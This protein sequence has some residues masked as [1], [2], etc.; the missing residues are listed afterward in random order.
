[1][2]LLG[3]WITKKQVHVISFVSTITKVDFEQITAATILFSKRKNLTILG[4]FIW[5]K[6]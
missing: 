2:V 1:M 4:F 3:P 6:D 5:K